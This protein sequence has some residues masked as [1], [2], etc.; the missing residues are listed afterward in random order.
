MIFF[1][2]FLIDG[3]VNHNIEN[4][5]AGREDAGIGTDQMMAHGAKDCFLIIH[6]PKI[7]YRIILFLHNQKF[8]ILIYI[9]YKYIYIT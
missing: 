4:S 7:K 3:T 2:D 8:I 9:I 6:C 1:F 5:K